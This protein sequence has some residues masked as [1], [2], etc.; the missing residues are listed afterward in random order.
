ML[1]PIRSWVRR[2]SGEHKYDASIAAFQNAV[3]A[4]PSAAQPMAEL[5]AAMVSAKQ[6]DKAIAYLQSA[7]KAKSD[8][9]RSLCAVG[10][11]RA[12]N[13]A[14]DQAEANFKAAISSQ[15][16]ND[17]G[18]QALGNLYLRQKKVDAALDVIQAGLKELPDNANLQLSLGRHSRIEGQITRARFPNTNHC[19]SS[20]PAPWLLSIIWQ[21]C[22]P[23][24][25]R[26]RRALSRRS[27]SP[28]AFRVH[29]SRNSGYAWLGVLSPRRLQ[30]VGAASRGSHSQPARRRSG[31]LSSRYELSWRR[32]ARQSIRAIQTG[33]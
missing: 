2:L 6:T 12:R 1:C 23:T 11:C 14:P 15:P 25:A 24:I 26:I 7:L 30:G 21:A 22:L 32:T 9:C 29:R 10:Q 13:N 28:P 16:K 8:Q 20:N 27:H 18:Y 19:S 5:V 31:A 4:A 17:I 3:A 33:A